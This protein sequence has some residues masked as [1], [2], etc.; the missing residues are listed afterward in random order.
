MNTHLLIGTGPR[1]VIALHGWFGHARGWGPLVDVLD[2]QDFS[3]AFMDCRGYGGMR[4]SGG[5]YTLDQIAQ[6]ALALADGLGWQRFSLIGHS[7]C[8]SAIQRVLVDAP[9][10][11]EKLVAIAPVSP[12]G[13]ALDNASWA[14]FSRTTKDAEARKR[15]LDMTTGLRLT[16]V[17]LDQMV[18]SSLAESDEAAY[19]A[20]LTAWAKTDFHAQIEGN[21]VQIKVIVGEHNP[22]LGAGA[23]ADTYMQ[24]YPNA[25]LEVMGNAG[26]YPMNETPIALATSIEKF[27]RG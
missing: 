23:M 18:A 1:K 17:W 3:Y 22:L 10:R 16:S 19:E 12:S 8:G 6:D 9:A 4:G 14:F 2:T 20:Y 15:L 26:H 24:W 21:P 11:V 13:M 25:T 5:P 7:M 27:L